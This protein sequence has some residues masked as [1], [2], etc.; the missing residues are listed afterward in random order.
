MKTNRYF[1]CFVLLQNRFIATESNLNVIA[2]GPIDV[3]PKSTT[4]QKPLETCA[5]TFNIPTADELSG[6]SSVISWELGLDDVS[7]EAV[8]LTAAAVK[9]NCY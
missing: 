9:V 4:L 3:K 1:A 7:D 5:K 8:E 6:L 2:I